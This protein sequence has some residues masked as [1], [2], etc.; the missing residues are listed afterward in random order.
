MLIA[1]YLSTYV[2]DMCNLGW[3]DIIYNYVDSTK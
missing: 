3:V 2:N 1:I